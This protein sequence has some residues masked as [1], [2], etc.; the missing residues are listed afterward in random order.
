MKTLM[1]IVV[2]GLFSST[3]LT[4]EQMNLLPNGSFEDGDFQIVET[5]EQVLNLCPVA[6]GETRLQ[7][8]SVSLSPDD[9]DQLA[10]TSGLEWVATP[11]GRYAGPDGHAAVDLVTGSDFFKIANSCLTVPDKRYQLSF[12]TANGG[13]LGVRIEGRSVLFLGN[14]PVTEDLVWRQII[15]PFTANS[16]TSKIV[17]WASQTGTVMSGGTGPALDGVRVVPIEDASLLVDV[18]AGLQIRGIPG[19]QYRIDYSREVDSGWHVLATITLPSTPYFFVDD[20]VPARGPKRFY[21]AVE[22]E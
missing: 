3:A 9:P 5:Y 22:L 14:F 10:T 19:R 17:F 20:S 6:I 1:S 2:I 13:M 8:W 4:E 7:G 16:E 18:F 12:W 15:I 11:P 21:R